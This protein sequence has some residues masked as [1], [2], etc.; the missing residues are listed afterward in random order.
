MALKSSA[1]HYGTIAVAIHW[2]SA[3]LVLGLLVSG[4]RAAGTIDPEAKAGLLRI[5]AVVGATVLALTLARIAW[6]IFADRRPAES[7]GT[8]RL[9][10]LAARAVHVLFYVVLVGMAASGIGM[11][12][13]SGAA[14]ILFA[15]APGPLPDFMEYPPRLAHGLGAFLL[16]ALVLAHVAAAFYH[17]FVLRDR[18]LA[19]MGLG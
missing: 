9:Q 8:P 7:A 5:H 1:N 10:G 4:F 13:L 3:A 6:W 16:V 12:V 17:Q 14:A 19:R 15:G 18:L 11:L 2:L